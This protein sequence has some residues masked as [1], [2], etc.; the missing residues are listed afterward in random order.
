MVEKII[1]SDIFLELRHNTKDTVHLSSKLREILGE[2]SNIS[3]L[4]LRAT[5]EIRT[6]GYIQEAVERTSVIL[7]AE[8]Y[9][10]DL[11]KTG[12]IKIGWLSR[13]MR[14]WRRQSGRDL[15]VG[16][17]GRLEKTRPS[18]EKGHLVDS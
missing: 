17:R 5:L 14:R 7:A 8:R 1:S 4:Q 12:W 9:V 15:R 11:L 6:A 18:H 3:S 16:R 13:R 10:M 2:K